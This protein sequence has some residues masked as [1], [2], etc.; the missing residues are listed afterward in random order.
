MQ[1]TEII[2][3][4]GAGYILTLAGYIVWLAFTDDHLTRKQNAAYLLFCFCV[5]Y[6]TFIG[7]HNIPFRGAVQLTIGLVSINVIYALIRGARKAEK[8]LSDYFKD[9]ITGFFNKPKDNETK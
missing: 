6:L 3:E 8:P 5:T 7:I 9:K 4:Y 1:W 2:S